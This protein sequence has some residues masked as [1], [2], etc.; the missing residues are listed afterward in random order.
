MHYWNSKFEIVGPKVLREF[1]HEHA[2]FLSA[3]RNHGLV[4]FSNL[5]SPRSA[6]LSSAN[7]F[8]CSSDLT[9]TVVLLCF[10]GGG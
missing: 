9:A 3:E 6:S 4:S 8:F 1:Q 10:H 5:S 7:A 2:G